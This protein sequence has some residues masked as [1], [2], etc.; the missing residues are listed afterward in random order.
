MIGSEEQL[1]FLELIGKELP[2]RVECYVIGG[3]AML[4][5]GLKSATKDI[6]LVFTSERER[7]MFSGALERIGFKEK[8]IKIFAH[9][10]QA[11]IRPVLM[12]RKDARFD[13]FLNEIISTRLSPGIISRIRE[14]HEFSNLIASIVSREDIIFLKCA[15]DR[16]GDRKDAAD[17]ISSSQVNWDTIEAESVWQTNNGKRMFT[18]FLFDF[19]ME[20]K[21]KYGAQIPLGAV[22]KITRQYEEGLEKYLKS[23][24]NE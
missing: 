2:G 16:E 6:D 10:D 3:S 22:K 7:N 13:L 8:N 9:G 4:F 21:E 23:K 17:I 14:K 24:G 12:E 1:A 18:V 5:Y 15:T 19:V 20:L 11:R